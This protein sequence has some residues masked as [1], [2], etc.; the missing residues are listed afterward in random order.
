MVSFRL[1]QSDSSDIKRAVAEAEHWLKNETSSRPT[2]Y[3][4]LN[5]NC[6]I[7]MCP[8][9]R[10]IHERDALLL[11]QIEY[12]RK[13]QRFKFIPSCLE[14]KSNTALSR[15]IWDQLER[16]NRKEARDGESVARRDGQE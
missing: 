11:G 8:S 3:L 5:C 4:I 9:T 16:L 10:G 2:V 13:K 6:N 15:M 7:C 1:H 12:E 14:T